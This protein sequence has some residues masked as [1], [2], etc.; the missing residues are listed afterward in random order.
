MAVVTF[1]L[2]GLK[3]KLA[4][5]DGRA[6][7]TRPDRLSIT[8][9]KLFLIL[10]CLITATSAQQVADPNFDPKVAHPAYTKNGPQGPVR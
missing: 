7:D 5:P 6:S 2:I 1:D 9:K 10:C 8:V 3:P 4:L